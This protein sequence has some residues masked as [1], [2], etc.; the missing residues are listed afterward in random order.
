MRMR[1]R[2]TRSGHIYVS[3]AVVCAF[4]AAALAVDVGDPAPNFGIVDSHDKTQHL[5]DYKGKYVVLEWHNHSCP[6]VQRQYDSGRMQQLQKEWT[7]KGVAWLMVSSSGPG[8]AGFLTLSQ[9]N[10]YV[11]Q[12]KASPTAAL[13]DSGGILGHLYGV[14]TTP[15][16]FVID[17]NGTVIYAGAIDDHYKKGQTDVAT[18]KN[19]VDAALTEALSG[20]RVTVPATIPYGC[21]VKYKDKSY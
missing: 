17:P 13:M 1:R 7:T 18:A 14:K 12:V 21:T 4:M 19:Y 20:K 2:A 6:A 15:Q 5:S 10:D 11:Q 16:M 8:T 3:A 9:E